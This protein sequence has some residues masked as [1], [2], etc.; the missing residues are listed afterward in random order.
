MGMGGNEN[1][2]FPSFCPRIADHQILVM[3]LCFGIVICRRLFGFTLDVHETLRSLTLHCVLSEDLVDFFLTI[4][5][6]PC[7]V[8][9]NGHLLSD[10]DTISTMGIGAGGNVNNQWE[11]ERNGNKTRVNLGVGMGINH[12]EWEEMGI[13]I[14]F[15]HTS[16]VETTF[17]VN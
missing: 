4:V 10:R 8:K 15:P 5:T 7:I 2:T 9:L 12:W 11:W 3:D 1:S 17:Q 6:V 14:L 16:A 13:L